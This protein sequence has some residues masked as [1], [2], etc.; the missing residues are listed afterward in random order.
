M[1]ISRSRSRLDDSGG[2]LNFVALEQVVLLALGTVRALQATNQEHG[3]TNS[4]KDGEDIRVS[5]SQ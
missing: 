5:S 1:A 4:D 3:H 2:P